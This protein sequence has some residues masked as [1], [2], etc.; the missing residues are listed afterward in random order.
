MFFRQ[1]RSDARKEPTATKL[2]AAVQLLKTVLVAP[3]NTK[4]TP[5][6]CNSHSHAVTAI[7]HSRS[8]VNQQ[9]D[10]VADQVNGI[11]IVVTTDPT[12]AH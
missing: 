9:S 8:R 6:P 1:L 12:I 7:A 5:T 4:T 10:L 11:L 2:F 3:T